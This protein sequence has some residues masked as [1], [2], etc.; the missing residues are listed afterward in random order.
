MRAFGA[1]DSTIDAGSATMSSPLMLPPI[2]TTAGGG[3]VAAMTPTAKGLA[4]SD[5]RSRFRQR[6]PLVSAS[7]N[8]GIS[9][10]TA[11]EDPTSMLAL[12][13]M[14]STSMPTLVLTAAA[15]GGG[16]AE[17]SSHSKGLDNSTSIQVLEMIPF[18]LTPMPAAMAAGGGGVE[19]AM[20]IPLA[21]TTTPPT[22][23]A[24]AMTPLSL[25][26]LLQVPTQMPGLFAIAPLM[27][28][29]AMTTSA[30][31]HYLPNP[32]ALRPLG[33]RKQLH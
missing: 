7:T 17:E 15:G 4:N 19:V 5:Y 21:S 10:A 33:L 16:T 8:G 23:L 18:P 14:S 25:T 9:N 31:I 13:T 26:L 28:A 2:A 20:L 32:T 12:V 11:L 3:G 29:L 22:A 30:S 27:S 1:L 6:L 24:P